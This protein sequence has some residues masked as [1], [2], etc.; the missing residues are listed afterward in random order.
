MDL[1]T[2]AIGLLVSDGEERRGAAG[3]R[4]NK[5]RSESPSDFISQEDSIPFGPIFPLPQFGEGAQVLNGV[6]EFSL[7]PD[8]EKRFLWYQKRTEKHYER[9]GKPLSSK[10]LTSKDER[11]MAKAEKEGLSNGEAALPIVGRGMGLLGVDVGK[12]FCRGIAGKGCLYK[13]LLRGLLRFQN[14]FVSGF[15]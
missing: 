4:E 13:P 8:F 7:P 10:T 12:T 3:G 6:S 9:Q 5:S 15:L 1:L 2:D 14:L 11:N